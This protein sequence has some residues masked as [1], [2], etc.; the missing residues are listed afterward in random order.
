[1]RH[2][3]RLLGLSLL[4]SLCASAH[5]ASIAVVLSE[6]SPVYQ[7]YA[8]ALRTE[9]RRDN[10]NIDVQL[11]DGEQLAARPLPDAQF[12][13]GVGNRAAQIIMGRDV[14][15]P[16]LLA[17]LPKSAYDRIA[18][19]RRDDKHI[20]GLF[21]DQP[22]QRYI[23]LVR[24]ALPD[25]ERVG[26]LAGPDSRDTVTRLA[27]AAR[28][29]KLRP[30]QESVASEADIF[31]ALQRMF[32]D[33]GVLLAVPDMTIFNSQTIPNILL[34]TYR[35]RVPVIGFS[36][37]YVRAGALVALY[38]TPAQIGQQSADIARAVMS[39]GALPAPQYPRLFTVG[40]NTHV[41]R[42]L[43]L[44]IESEGVVREKLEKLERP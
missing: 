34:S 32:G 21:I 11:I 37:A 22:P 26:M 16:I 38:S 14:K 36:Q 2:L 13:I 35:F 1:M 15:A 18:A 9:L 8:N 17:L 42:S 19:G 23:D 20:T 25:A 27:Q 4:V 12:V 3:A 24:T 30:V 33:G 29:R 6:P 31:P 44:Q 39:G 28:E 41:A 5:A 40:V 10:P 43:G 7:E